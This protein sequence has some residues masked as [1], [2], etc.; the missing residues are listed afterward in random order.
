MRPTSTTLVAGVAALVA[1]GVAAASPPR[2]VVKVG[3][4]HIY[5]RSE[6]HPRETVVCRY[7]RHTLRVSAP[8]GVETGAST[9]LPMRSDPS[10]T[11]FYLGVSVA[12]G[13][14]YAVVCG[15]GGELIMPYLR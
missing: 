7:R 9:A 2:L 14:R 12:P 4:K 15:L 8:T 11:V 10:R 1:A 13:G 6:L 5:T 3:T